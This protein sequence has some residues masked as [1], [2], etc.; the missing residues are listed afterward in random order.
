MKLSSQQTNEK[1]ATDVRRAKMQTVCI[2][3]RQ[4]K[5]VGFNVCS[6]LSSAQTLFPEHFRT[7]MGHTRA[8]TNVEGSFPQRK[9]LS[10]K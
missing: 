8:H 6:L 3:H 1:R 10:E 9:Q 7:E 5:H 2:N 4:Q